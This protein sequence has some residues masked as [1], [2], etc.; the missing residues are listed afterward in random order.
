ME[1]VQGTR[2]L[3][4]SVNSLEGTSGDFC[5]QLEERNSVATLIPNGM[6]A[7]RD[8]IDRILASNTF[9][10]S[11]V[12]RRLLRFLAD[13]TFAGTADDLKEYSVGLDALGKPATYDPRQDAAVR[14][15]ASRLRQKLDD[16]YRNEGKS[17]SLI[18]ELPKGRFKIA[19]HPRGVETLPVVPA[20]LPPVVIP[21][22]AEVVA[23]PAIVP[24]TSKM[25]RNVAI[26]AT[27]IALVFAFVTVW[28]LARTS[29]TLATTRAASGSTPELD[30]LWRPFL[31]PA[32]HLIIAF[33]NPL[34]VR[35]QRKAGVDVVF[36]T[37]GDNSWEDVLASSELPA[38]K[39]AL[40][41]DLATPTFNLVERSNLI[42]TFAL[43]QFFA[44]RREDVS[45]A[46]AD[47][48]SWQQLS[49]NDVI[50]FGPFMIDGGAS[51]LPVKTPL[52]LEKGGIRNL[53]PAAGEPSVYPDTDFQHSPSN[54]E[55]LE[56]VSM[57]PGPLGRTTVVTFSSNNK[58][59][60]IGGV[61]SLTDP[62][63]AKV[64]VEKLRDP[65][66]KMPSYFQLVLR[67]KYRDGTLTHVSYVT[68]RALAMAQSSVETGSAK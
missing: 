21:Q 60:V 5:M 35:L 63:F 25:W 23:P 46:R 59:G 17:D 57:M 37:S 41:S 49:D 14:L 29:K 32:R 38:L 18:V 65:S 9:H 33:V 55:A 64:I 36:R 56:L 8:Q 68:H 66:G 10:A 13:K 45:L 62:A 20:P 2:S 44:H 61:Q 53:L 52:V 42:S 48:V 67:M 22:P 34:F 40:G 6:E 58:W 1:W 54:G 26:G 47:E 43:S 31:S 28:S 4:L 30:A 50:L 24:D 7:A 51:A 27:A 3:P 19:W 11:D 39:K 12:L 15:H 16:Y